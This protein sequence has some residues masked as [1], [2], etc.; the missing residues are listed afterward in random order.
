MVYTQR[1]WT[2]RILLFVQH[3]AVPHHADAAHDAKVI[4]G[5]LVGSLGLEFY[6]RLPPS[7]YQL[8][9]QINNVAFVGSH[10]RLR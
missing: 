3:A 9:E 7:Y 5:A 6:S 8:K 10:L 2:T 4:Y 1:N